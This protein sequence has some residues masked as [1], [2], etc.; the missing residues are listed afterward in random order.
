MGLVLQR[1]EGVGRAGT[2]EVRE[3]VGLVLQ[4]SEVEGGAGTPEE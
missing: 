4:R 2:P 3:R 1:S